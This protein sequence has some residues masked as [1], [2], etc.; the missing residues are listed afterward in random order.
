[1]LDGL[2][3]DYFLNRVRR[4]NLFRFGLVVLRRL[5]FGRVPDRFFSAL[6]VIFD[7]GDFALLFVVRRRSALRWHVKRFRLA[8][9]VGRVFAGVSRRFV[10]TV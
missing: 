2:G 8:G 6:I 3:T 9:L 7:S 10:V 5:L 1:M 4:V